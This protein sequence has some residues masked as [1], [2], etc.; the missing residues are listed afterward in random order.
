M[1]FDFSSLPPRERYAIL[2][3]VVVPRPIAFVTTVDEAGVPNAAPYSFFNAMGSDPPIVA[4]GIGDRSPGV[5]KD[6]AANILATNEFVVNVVVEAIAEQMN[7]AATDFP[8]GMDELAA[9]GLT[10][11][12]S[13]AVKPPR[14][15]ESPVSL[16]CRHVQT[17]TIGRNRV[18]IGEV[19]HVHI[20]DELLD[21][22]RRVK[23]GALPAV[24]RLQSPGW[25]CNTRDQFEIDRL[26]YEQFVNKSGNAERRK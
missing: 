25:Y 1:E 9:V 10:A 18:V 26:S 22:R 13:K 23:P 8:K 12:A 20:A 5:P 16:E 21:E 2:T 6:T 19:L 17:L 14:I 3:S 7:L 15:A 24:G 4:L 11:V